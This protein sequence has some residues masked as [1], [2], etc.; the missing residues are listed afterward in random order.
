MCQNRKLVPYEM[1]HRTITSYLPA[2]TKLWPRL[3]F[4]SCLWF[5][6]QGGLPQC[7][8]GYCYPHKKEAPPRKQT[9][10]AK[11]TPPGRRH[12][13]CQGDPLQTHTQ[14]G[15][16]SGLDPGS[17]PRGKLRGVRSRSTPKGKI[18]GDQIQALPPAYGQ[19]VASMHPTGMH[20]CF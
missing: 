9:P 3:C 15:N 11:E 13:P 18:E 20:S 19:W 17:H 5:C 1:A 8:L 10:P 16:C 6:P 14:G 7:M 12:S 4:Y 2:A